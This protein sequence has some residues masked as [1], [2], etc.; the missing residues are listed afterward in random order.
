MNII[1]D[2]EVVEAIENTSQELLLTMIIHESD[3]SSQKW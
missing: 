2:S 3:A 1:E